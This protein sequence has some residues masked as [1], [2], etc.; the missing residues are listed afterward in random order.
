[1]FIAYN[2]VSP[3]TYNK[4]IIFKQHVASIVYPEKME[5][6]RGNDYINMYK[7]VMTNGHTYYTDNIESYSSILLEE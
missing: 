4:V 1:M 5:D 7:I 6:L 2:Y 3:E